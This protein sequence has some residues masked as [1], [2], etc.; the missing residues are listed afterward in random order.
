[1]WSGGVLQNKQAGTFSHVHVIIKLHLKKQKK[2]K[3]QPLRTAKQQQQ[4]KLQTCFK[5]FLIMDHYK[6]GIFS[7]GCKHNHG[8]LC[9]YSARA[10]HLTWQACKY[11]R[12]T[13]IMFKNKN[14]FIFIFK[15]S[16]NIPRRGGAKHSNTMGNGNGHGCRDPFISHIKLRLFKLNLKLHVAVIPIFRWQ[17]AI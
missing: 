6:P 7:A 17:G 14:K 9:F 15:S 13:V 4:L 12:Q 3:K 11:Y 8:T 10:N 16:P 1:M 5:L 2:T